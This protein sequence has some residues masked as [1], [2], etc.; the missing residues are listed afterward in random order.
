MGKFQQKWIQILTKM[1]SSNKNGHLQGQCQ[2]HD[3]SHLQVLEDFQ[4]FPQKIL[5]LVQAIPVPTWE[6]PQNHSHAAPGNKGRG[7]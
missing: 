4:D 1:A 7:V 2:F 3:F 5:Q 6:V